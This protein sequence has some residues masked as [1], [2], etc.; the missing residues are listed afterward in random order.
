M[1]TNN[2]LY[3]FKP[4][5]HNIIFKM[6]IKKTVRDYIKKKNVILLKTHFVCFFFILS[7]T[8][9]TEE[10]DDNLYTC[11]EKYSINNR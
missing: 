1:N 3:T 4:Y 8:R 11:G 6:S 9:K 7:L 2:K 5:L 10:A